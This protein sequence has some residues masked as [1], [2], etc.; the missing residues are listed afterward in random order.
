MKFEWM[1]ERAEL[2]FIYGWLSKKSILSH[3]RLL[4]NVEMWGKHLVYATND[5]IV[6]F[7]LLLSLAEMF[8]LLRKSPV[9][10]VLFRV[11]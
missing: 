2:S 3:N 6:I 4:H 5:E 10:S 7:S 11:K 1:C 8:F 9:N